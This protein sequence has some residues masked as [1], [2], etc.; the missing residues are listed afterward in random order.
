MSN[1]SLRRKMWPTGTCPNFFAVE[2]S[3]P[4]VG[5]PTKRRLVASHDPARMR[6]R[7]QHEAVFISLVSQWN[8]AARTSSLFLAVAFELRH[9]STAR[10]AH[11]LV[12]RTRTISVAAVS[13]K[14]LSSEHSTKLSNGLG[15]LSALSVCGCCA[16]L[17]AA[18]ARRRTVHNSAPYIPILFRLLHVLLRT[19]DARLMCARLGSWV[20][21]STSRL[22][23]EAVR[24]PLK[25]V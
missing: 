16:Q 17:S 25:Q 9:Q 6:V 13:Y 2:C 21:R 10:R 4:N 8:L 1:L 14:C 22:W 23:A 20:R 18:P 24:F 3:R 5:R 15:A 11:L 19:L 7:K 12:S